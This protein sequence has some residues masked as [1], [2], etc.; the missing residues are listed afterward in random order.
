[1]DAGYAL[2]LSAGLLAALNPC[3]FAMLPVYLSFLLLDETTPVHRWAAVGRALALTAAMTLGFVAVFGGFGLLAA[4]AADLVARHLPWVSVGIGLTLVALGAWLLAGRTL[5]A[6][7]PRPVGGAPVSRRFASM[8]GF[9]AAYAIASLGCT[10]GP[11]LA[12]VVAGFRAGSPAAGLGLF[13]TYAAGMALVVGTVSLAVAL[14]KVSVVRRL[15][16]AGGV[17]GRA[18]GALMVLG[19]AYVAW[20]GA[21]E[22]RVFAG[23]SGDDRVVDAAAQV[24]AGLSSAVAWLGPFGVAAIAAVL[25]AAIAAV[26]TA[27]H[28]A[29]RRITDNRAGADRPA[30]SRPQ[31]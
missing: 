25:L 19:G 22:L 3:G 26:L 29:G 1:L 27:R 31:P 5:P 18:G 2:A 24:Q 12:V 28:R 30:P 21:Y 6:P 23:G 4:P 14:A 17:V 15:R 10:V 13:V 7:A 8:V 9:G 16:R 11:F 20:Y